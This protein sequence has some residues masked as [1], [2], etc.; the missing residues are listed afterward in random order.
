M[1]V[2]QKYTLGAPAVSKTPEEYVIIEMYNTSFNER[3]Q[4]VRRSVLI[5]GENYWPVK[6]K[7]RSTGHTKSVNL[8][9]DK[10]TVQVFGKETMEN[11]TK[12]NQ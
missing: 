6:L 10:P 2:W 3:H 1:D 11:A 7:H 5:K 9:S 12:P 4:S 8:H